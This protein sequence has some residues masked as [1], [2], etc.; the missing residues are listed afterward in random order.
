M[1]RGY[2]G[3]SAGKPAAPK[4]YRVVRSGESWRVEVNGCFTRL[5]PDRKSANRLTRQ[6]QGQRNH[7]NR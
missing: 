7:L 2:E 5:I 1:M 3:V 4:R 6:L